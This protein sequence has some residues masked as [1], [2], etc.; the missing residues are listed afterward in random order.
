MRTTLG[1]LL[2]FA[3]ATTG[4]EAIGSLGQD[5]I[6]I[7]SVVRSPDLEAP[8]GT[9]LQQGIV[10]A[11]VFF[12]EKDTGVDILAGPPTA[13]LGA[14]VQLVIYK[15]LDDVLTNVTLPGHGDGHYAT[16]SVDAPELVYA[17]GAEYRTEVDEDPSQVPYV[18]DV[19]SAPVAEPPVLEVTPAAGVDFSVSRQGSDTAFVSVLRLD[20][21]GAQETW[22][23]RPS[24][25]EGLLSAVVDP[26]PY[27]AASFDIPGQEAI[28]TAGSYAVVLTTLERG[29]PDTSLFPASGVFVGASA[30]K[31]FVVE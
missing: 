15:Q 19:A 3:L 10:V 24:D 27:Q 23:N 18:V 25:V 8:D 11:D 12:G 21:S 1:T 13:I 14:N 30:A 16:N 28:P 4:C 22:T 9:P 6:V 7:G 26:S 20:P 31:S 17:A 5:K 29:I 2:V